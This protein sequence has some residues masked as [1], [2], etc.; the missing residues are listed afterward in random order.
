MLGALNLG[1]IR[2]KLLEVGYKAE[3]REGKLLI[4][5]RILLFS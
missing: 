3:F 2:N 5:D 1:E 4:N